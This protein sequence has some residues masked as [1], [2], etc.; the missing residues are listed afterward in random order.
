MASP[1]FEQFGIP[2]RARLKTGFDPGGAA[3]GE[4]ATNWGVDQCRHGARD[5]FELIG[6]RAEHRDRADEPARVRMGRLAEEGGDVRLLDDLAGVHD[7]YPVGHLRHHT[8]IVGDED[9]RRVEL[10]FQIDH[11]VEDLSLDGHVERRG[12]LIGDQ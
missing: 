10:F 5:H 9:H 11:Q 7:R 12:G 4:A 1:D 2:L 6:D 8:E 3:V